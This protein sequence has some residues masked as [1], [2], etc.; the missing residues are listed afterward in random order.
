MGVTK[1]AVNGSKPNLESKPSSPSLFE[2]YV[3]SIVGIGSALL[4]F[5]AARNSFTW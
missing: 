1:K 4:T 2:A 3:L 5:A